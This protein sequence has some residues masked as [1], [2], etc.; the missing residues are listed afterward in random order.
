M[1]EQYFAD[2]LIV[3]AEEILLGE[4]EACPELK[5]RRIRGAHEALERLQWLHRKWVREV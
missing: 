1:D 4:A 2:C 5:A 3:L